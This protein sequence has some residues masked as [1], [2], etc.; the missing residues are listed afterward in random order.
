MSLIATA[1]DRMLGAI[2]PRADAEA[3]SCPGGCFRQTCYCSTKYHK[4]YNRCVN[5]VRECVG[6]FITVYSC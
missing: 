3:A 5:T 6:C 2:V 1:A 4:W